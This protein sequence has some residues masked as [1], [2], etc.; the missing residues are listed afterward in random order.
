MS[1]P[2][3]LKSK[4][5]SPVVYAPPR[6]DTVAYLI[7][8]AI[9]FALGLLVGYLINNNGDSDDSGSVS[10]A[11]AVESTLIA[12]TPTATP[13]PTRAPIQLTFSEKDYAKGDPNAPIKL[14]EFS[15]Y[16]CPYCTRFYQT[17]LNPILEQYEGYVE[18]VYR[19]YPIFGE[20]SYQASHGAYCANEQDKF[21]EYHDLIFASQANQIPINEELLTTLA[22]ET[23]LDMESFNT[24]FA[25][26][27]I[28]DGIIANVVD[29]QSLMGRTGTPTFLINGR[30]VVGAQPFENFVAIINEELLAMG[31]EPPAIDT[32]S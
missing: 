18:F 32:G 13:E 4:E 9:F 19:D 17:T 24:C 26:Q 31:I 12:L 29:A 22:E 16:Q 5:E 20:P 15:D 2:I 21:W 7:T 27:T 3:E 10:V 25:D 23:E 14:V 1:E 6:N 30:R 11:Q 8:A 28:L